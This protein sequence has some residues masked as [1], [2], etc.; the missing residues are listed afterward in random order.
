MTALRLSFSPEQSVATGISVVENARVACSCAVFRSSRKAQF[1]QRHHRASMR[2]GN[3]ARCAECE[4]SQVRQKAYVAVLA[5]V[6]LCTCLGVLLNWGKSQVLPTRIPVCNLHLRAVQPPLSNV[7]ALRQI[8][9]QRCEVRAPTSQSDVATARC[10]QE[11][12]VVAR[13]TQTVIQSRYETTQCRLV[14]NGVIALLPKRL[15]TFI[16]L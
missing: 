4:S 16:I 12:P 15:S 3:L 7:E 10:S 14:H 13:L 6:E 8:V 2:R 1:A 11:I 5:V 9:A